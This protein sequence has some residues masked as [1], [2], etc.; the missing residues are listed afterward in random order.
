MKAASMKRAKEENAKD[1]SS[2]TT[3][4]QLL[5]ESDNNPFYKD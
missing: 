1:R 3:K 5:T 2:N 4:G